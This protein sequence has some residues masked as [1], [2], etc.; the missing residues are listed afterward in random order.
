MIEKMAI[1]VVGQ[2]CEENLIEKRM[3]EYYIYVLESLTENVITLGSILLL[4]LVFNI[5]FPTV[6]FLVFFMSLRKRTGGF[7]LNSFIQCY[8]GTISI[9]VSVIFVNSC[10]MRFPQILLGM[11]FLSICVIELIGTVNHPNMHMSIEELVEAKKAARIIAALEGSIISF[12][13][14]VG[15]KMVY[16]GYMSM[17]IIVC[18]ALLC[19]AKILKQEVKNNEA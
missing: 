9:Y 5:V 2:M 15:V 3:E 8:L 11:T 16:I 1:S 10:L 4:S 12:F 13:A 17:A 18:A 7:H 14:Y 6:L 19:I